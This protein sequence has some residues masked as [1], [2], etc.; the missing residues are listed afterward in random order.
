M[1]QKLKAVF[2]KTGDMRFISHLDLI[3]MFQRA[4]R[5]AGLPVVVTRGYTP[6]LKISITKALK[7][8]LESSN[9]EAI[10]YMDEDVK[11]EI[12]IKSINGKLP[13]GLKIEK[14]ERLEQNA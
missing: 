3:R 11:P 4:S 7:L 6:R 8:G 1:T 12:F 2:S 13:N 10:F 5:R 14:A 9:E